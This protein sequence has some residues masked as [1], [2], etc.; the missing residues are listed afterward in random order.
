MATVHIK[1]RLESGV[2]NWEVRPP[3]LRIPHDPHA[4]VQI[5]WNLDSDADFLTDGGIVFKPDPA[6]V[7]TTPAGDAKHY[8]STETNDNAGPLAV[9]Y[10][11]SINVTLGGQ[12]FTLDPD[13]SNDPPPPGG[14]GDEADDDDDDNQGGGGGKPPGHNHR[15]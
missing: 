6:W 7:G 13:V 10:H 5:D 12:V 8:Q 1:F 11:Y 14:G 4:Q 2:P 3:R 15:S 9:R